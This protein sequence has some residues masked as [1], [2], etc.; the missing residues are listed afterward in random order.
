VEVALKTPDDRVENRRLSLRGEGSFA[1]A[2]LATQLLDE[3]RRKLQSGRESRHE[4]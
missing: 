3:L 4:R 1:R 2:R